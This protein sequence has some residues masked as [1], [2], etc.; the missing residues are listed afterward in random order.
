MFRDGN[1]IR[2]NKLK[3]MV[4]I[5]T[6]EEALNIIDCGVDIID[7]KNP[8]EGALGANL[9][10]ITRNII[11]EVRKFSEVSVTLG[12]MPYL[13]GTASLS[14]LGAALLGVDYIKVGLLG[15]KNIKE[16]LNISSSITRTFQEFKVNAK[17]IIAGYADYKNQR[18]ISPL[19]LPKIAIQSGAWGL[20]IDVKEKNNNGLFN[21]LS[22]EELK[23]FVDESHSLGLNVA[24]AGSLGLN[25]VQTIIKIGSDIMGV[26]RGV[27]ISQHGTYI[28]DRHK[29]EEM[30]SSAYLKRPSV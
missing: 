6:P 19:I 27:S 23:K 25:D 30:V 29:V 8:S 1:R 17:L 20:L 2:R 9:P 5:T 28:I 11:N 12:D 3:I 13:P 10:W 14:A 4:S 24:L 15:P 18:C 21:Y 7:I 16:A 22:F 26:R